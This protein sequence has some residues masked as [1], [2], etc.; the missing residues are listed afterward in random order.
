[1]AV[2]GGRANRFGRTPSHEA[3]RRADAPASRICGRPRGP[4]ANPAGA[5][6]TTIVPAPVFAMRIALRAAPTRVTC[7]SDA[8]SATAG[9]G[10][11][12]LATP[13][14][15]AATKIAAARAITARPP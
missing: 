11:L 13:G 14:A 10:G 3:A 6:S 1:N 4:R 9:R 7:A 8:L 15:A 12:A 5:T 2:P